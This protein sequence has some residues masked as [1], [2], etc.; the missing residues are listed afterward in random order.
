M[1]KPNQM[2]KIFKGVL[3]V[4]ALC[5]SLPT[6]AQR[7]LKDF[8]QNWEFFQPQND[9]YHID[10]PNGEDLG[11]LRIDLWKNVD[12]PHTF[13][14]KDM[15]VDRNFYTGSVI[16]Q[17]QF[18][19]KKTSTNKR[20]F[21]KF[22]G[23]GSVAKVYVN[24]KYIGEHKGGYSQFVYEI[25][26]SLDYDQENTI[27]VV[28]NNEARKDVIPINQFLFPIYGGI[29]RPVELISTNSTQFT[30][31]DNASPGIFISQKNVSSKKAELEIKAKLNTSEQKVQQAVLITSIKDDKGKTVARQ[32][33]KVNISP[34]GTTFSTQ[35]IQLK[36]PHLWDGV[37]DPY[38][39]TVSSK[40]VQNGTTLD[41]VEQNL[42]VRKIE[43]KA[44]K[45][46]YLNGEKY[47][48]HGV[49]RHQDL[50]EYG[51]AL[52]YEQHKRDF[53]LMK[54]MGVTTV[55]LAHYQQAPAVYDLAD[56]YGF[57]VWAEIP[58]VNAVS[59]QESA[60]AKHQLRELIKQNYNHPSIFI[61]GMHNEVYSKN[62]DGEVPQL[63]RE[64]NDIAKT[65]DPYRYTGS[66]N[67]YA[68]VDRPEN[69]NTD[70]Q[71]INHYF[72]WYGGEIGD[73]ED[74]AE[75]LE[76]NYPNYKI[77]L[78][79]YGADGNIDIGAEKVEKPENV[80]SGD[81]SPEN[82]QTETHIQQWEII[83]QHPIIAASYIWNM[84][85]FAVPMWNRGGVNARNLKGLITFDRKRKKDAFYWYKANWNDEP[86]LYLANRRDSIRHES[87]TKIQ[88]FSNLKKVMFIINGK[89]YTPKKGVNDKHWILKNSPLQEGE[90]IIEVKGHQNGKKFTDKMK[91]ILK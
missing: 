89:E 62:K 73:L 25:T 60:N 20:T 26:N 78:T 74:W 23:V 6:I 76:Q 35:Q 16:Y 71:G 32:K 19:P 8:N 10:F 5:C 81:S 40:I 34:Q 87:N 54:E 1:N 7:K 44:G 42:G 4:L 91:W 41:N 58:F 79:E 70:V 72:G 2:S 38:L 59:Y 90:N 47:P 9:T 77:F 55:R 64:L 31:T 82:Y 21:I 39:Y 68:K 36:K 65:L 48:M 18:T 61:W 86:M 27:S 56:K 50:W 37:K 45:G 33:K 88:A 15:Q 69:L 17:K 30:V 13:N 57:L 83:E 51:S 12:L 66:V 24:K 63:T 75:N 22:K 53:E 85:E 43:I 84:F 28:A 67:G 49:A 29:Y 11:S 52:S 80:V 46:V 3:F 14:A